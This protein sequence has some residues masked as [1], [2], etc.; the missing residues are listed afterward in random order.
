MI[1]RE[2][3]VPVILRLSIVV[4]TA[5]LFG[6]RDATESTADHA[7]TDAPPPI[8][9]PDD[10]AEPASTSGTNDAVNGD[11][12]DDGGSVRED[13][14]Q[15]QPAAIYQVL[16]DKALEP[17]FAAMNAEIKARL[18]RV[19]HDRS[20]R[21][22]AFGAHFST[23]MQ[24]AISVGYGDEPLR[25][26]LAPK[27]RMHAGEVGFTLTA[28][29]VLMLVDEGRLDLNARIAS[30]LGGATW[31][32]RLPNHDTITIEHLLNQT[33]GLPDFRH[34]TSFWD[35]RRADD[36]RT[37]TPEERIA[38][39]LDMDPLHN[40][41]AGYAPSATNGILLG[42]VL[43][44]LTGTDYNEL[45]R[46]RLLEPLEMSLTTPAYTVKIGA[47]ATGY[48]DPDDG[49]FG[50][51]GRVY[52]RGVFDFNPQYAWASGNVVTSPQDLAKW[53]WLYCSGYVIQPSTVARAA[54]GVVIPPLAQRRVA[55]LGMVVRGSPF[56]AAL[57]ARGHF[58]GY[59]T[60][61]AYYPT[62]QLAASI[63]MN[64][65]AAMTADELEALLDELVTV[66]EPYRVKAR[67]IVPHHMP[68]V[69]VPEQISS[70]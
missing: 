54:S 58:P 20:I 59:R 5:A 26:T 62:L 49:V 29:L 14:V 34:D 48:E 32:Q 42:M 31:M 45:V 70:P 56:T 66:V 53:W 35:D 52:R 40:V 65:P 55:G 28:A 41:G 64:E 39:V 2:V 63:Q 38:Y 36:L 47:I 1:R 11:T 57:S 8:D 23:T 67:E 51:E 69:D 15:E 68:N 17:V 10:V 18:E 19:M 21:G 25:Q 13:G 3:L 9:R 61:I 33:S 60:A 27:L 30:L 37:F 16:P 46:T 4:L 24:S 22:I 6:C 50:I 44:S 7:G 43:E 12:P